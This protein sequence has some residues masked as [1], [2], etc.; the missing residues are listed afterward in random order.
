MPTIKSFTQLFVWQKAHIL[1]LNIYKM[2]GN[3]PK[4]EIFGLTDQ[5]RRA[6]VSVSANIAEGFKRISPKE[7]LRFYNIAASSL[8]ELYA[9]LLLAKDLGYLPS[10]DIKAFQ[11]RDETSKL[12]HT[13]LRRIK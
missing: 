9:E 5:L 12:L 10:L 13:W 3:F 8:E 2:T 11:L 7:Q 1:A 4:R 6:A